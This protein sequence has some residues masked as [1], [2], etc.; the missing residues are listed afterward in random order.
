MAVRLEIPELGVE[1]FIIFLV[2]GM[3]LQ[4][5]SRKVKGN[6]EIRKYGNKEIRE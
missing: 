6:K 3:A 2:C 1:V 5:N 4:S